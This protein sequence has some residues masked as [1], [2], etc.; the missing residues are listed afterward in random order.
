MKNYIY[1]FLLISFSFNNVFSQ[2]L[3][4]LKNGDE[5][6]V[7]ITEVSDNSIK[8]KKMDFLKGPNFNI[9][10]SDIF[11]IKY[12]NGEKQLFNN[13][14]NSNNS[15]KSNESYSEINE[16]TAVALYSARTLTSKTL[17]VGSMVEFRVNID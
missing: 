5:L 11:L 13:D 12:S 7:K 1:L 10:T 9:N 2:D 3:I 4:M 16:G 17:A 6:T 14:V 15:I 8:Y